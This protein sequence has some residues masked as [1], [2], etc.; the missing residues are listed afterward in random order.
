METKTFF[1]FFF[2]S[3]LAPCHLSLL[4]SYCANV[5]SNKFSAAGL[6]VSLP[7]ETRLASLD[8]SEE[9]DGQGKREADN[10]RESGKIIGKISEGA[11][12]GV[13]GM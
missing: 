8:Y 10:L 6:Y 7:Q 11:A 3:S 12:K 4:L 5:A 9:L 1:A 13:K 2:F